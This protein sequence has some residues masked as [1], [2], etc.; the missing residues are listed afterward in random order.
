MKS[1]CDPDPP[2]GLLEKLAGLGEFSIR[3][4]YYPELQQRL[5]ELE[6]LKAFLD[7]S[8][9][10]IFLI[11]APSGRI[12]DVN[13]SASRQMG[14][15]REEFLAASLFDMSELGQSAAAEELMR[16]PVESDGGGVLVVTRLFLKDGGTF[17]AELSLNRME[18]RGNSFVLVVARD[19][20]ERA[21]VEAELLRAKEY[22]EDLIQGANVIVVG[23]DTAGRVILF[24]RTAEQIT[25]YTSAEVLGNNW[26]ETVSRCH[27][28]PG[29]CQRFP[30][31]CAELERLK[32]TATHGTFENEIVTKD[33]RIRIIS[34]RNNVISYG[35]EI[36]GTLSF[37]IDVTEQRRT[38]ADLRESEQ[39][40]RQLNETLEQ[41]IEQAVDE[42]EQKNRMLIMQ[43]RQAVMGEM[44]SNIAHQWRQP[45]N[46][47]GLLAQGLQISC[48]VG[49]FTKELL[50]E[51]VGEIV[52]IIQHMSKTIDDFRYFFRPSK[53]KEKF[54]VREVVEKTLTLLQASMAER[55][56]A[57][58]IEVTGEPIVNGFPNEFSQVL[59]NIISNARDAFAAGAPKRSDPVVAIRCYTEGGKTVVKVTDNAGGIPEDIIGKVFEPY[60]TTK[61]PDQGTGIGLYMCKN[62]IEKNMHGVISARNVGGGAEFTI[63][64]G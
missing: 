46:T 7:H 2:E 13:Q 43:S 14:W 64:L 48:E 39:R 54:K 27:R 62:I 26:F 19:I 36:T 42:L 61:G 57:I 10:A 55:K 60:F 20:T 41:R 45:L 59:L 11:E 18:F 3:K 24:N 32:V 1:R 47:L 16:L 38:E 49:Q 51:T 15:T 56:I 25:G 21:R 44:I 12:T 63:E 33:G 30:E 5:E 6:R 9:D 50:D 29:R 28:F 52:A 58:R 37:G 17:P 8:N 4:T 40:Y 31:G 34:W 35:E 53:E 23:L 22:T